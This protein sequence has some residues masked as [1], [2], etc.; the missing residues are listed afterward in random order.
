ME[1]LRKAQKF[2][3]KQPWGSFGRGGSLL[4]GQ[5]NFRVEFN[6]LPIPSP[7]TPQPLVSP[8]NVLGVW[9]KKNGRVNEA[10]AMISIPKNIF[11]GVSGLF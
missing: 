1:A 11:S 2:R 4:L 3:M 10:V 5:S 6:Q 8:V 9:A 7:H